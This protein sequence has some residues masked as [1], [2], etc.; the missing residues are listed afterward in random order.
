MTRNLAIDDRRLWDSLMQMAEIGATPKGGVCRLA[1]SD[2]D[3]QGRDLF[4]RWCEEAG[5]TVGVDEFG[6]VFA[7]RPGRNPD[8][9]AVATGSH[10]DTQ[11]TGGRFDGVY[12]VLAGLEVIRTLN[13]H[14]IETEAPVEV[15]VW[16]NEEGAR[17]APAMVGSGVHA[18]AFSLDYARSQKDHDGVTQG[19][20][21]DAIGYHGDEPV[22]SRK[23]GAFFEAHI[24]QGPVLETEGRTIGIVEGVQGVRW[25][26]AR[27][28]GAECHAGPSPMTTRRDALAGAAEMLNLVYDIALAHAPAGRCTVGEFRIYPGS[29]NTVPG[30]TEFTVDMR[31]PDPAHMDRMH[32]EL[33]EIVAEVAR[34]RHLEAHIEEIWYSPPVAFDPQ[35][36]AA[37]AKG[38]ELMGYDAMPIT[39]GA[40]HDSVYISR[41]A[42]TAMIF[43]PC[44]DGISHAE[45]EDATPEHCAAGA[46]VLLHAMLERAGH[47]GG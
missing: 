40:G 11:P 14:G 45:I 43:V 23:F 4:R 39:S 33:L 17:F 12:G 35:C 8:M 18:G 36:V 15:V 34:R 5:C 38:A 29:R 32:A 13:D 1:L 37:V 10:L 27:V 31:H 21:L 16:T 2:L 6:N 41:V 24:E 46:N 22:G 30:S 3:R 19:E 28:V 44:K 47:P 20:A 25:Y 26:D 42:P 7:R 9:P